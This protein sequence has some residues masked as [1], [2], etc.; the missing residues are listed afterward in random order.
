MPFFEKKGV[1]LEFILQRRMYP[2][3]SGRIHSF[4]KRKGFSLQSLTQ[5]YQKFEIYSQNIFTNN[6]FISESVYSNA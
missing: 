4:L 6:E 5:H 3:R 1:G 2:E